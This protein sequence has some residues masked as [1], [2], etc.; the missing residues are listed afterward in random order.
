MTELNIKLPW[1]DQF[2]HYMCTNVRAFKTKLALFLE[3]MSYKS[4]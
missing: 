2:V 1:K 4:H 3:Q